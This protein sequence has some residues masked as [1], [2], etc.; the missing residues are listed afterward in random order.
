[1][2]CPTCHTDV[3]KALPGDGILPKC[4]KCGSNVLPPEA[5]AELE[6]FRARLAQFGL[7]GDH[8]TRSAGAA[9]GES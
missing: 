1:M 2:N 6:G 4:P 9:K 8:L 7:E 5:E 3:S